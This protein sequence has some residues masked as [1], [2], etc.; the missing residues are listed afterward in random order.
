[1]RIPTLWSKHL[2][3]AILFDDTEL[4]SIS[5]QSPLATITEVV[6]GGVHGAPYSIGDYGFYSDPQFSSVVH[7]AQNDTR[8][9]LQDA[10]YLSD[11]EWKLVDERLETLIR[12]SDLIR[13][14]SVVRGDSFLAIAIRENAYQVACQL[15]DCKV[16][17]FSINILN[18]NTSHVCK[19][20]CGVLN[21][22]LRNYMSLQQQRDATEFIAPSKRR[23][24][25]V[26]V[27]AFLSKFR[28][29]VS[30]LK[31]LLNELFRRQGLVESE[32]NKQRLAELRKH[33]RVTLF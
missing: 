29:M 17:I 4:C 1:M 11:L 7:Q 30:F 18:E 20:Q 26:E 24:Q 32:Q 27:E 3:D 33:V 19:G 8:T 14:Q 12:H 13:F 5:L 23:E 28:G 9:R 22:L 15:I 2:I 10:S 6:E 16:D 25:Q 21:L 31:Y